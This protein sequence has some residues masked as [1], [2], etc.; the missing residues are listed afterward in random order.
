MKVLTVILYL[1]LA[2]GFSA[3]AQDALYIVD[4]QPS[5]AN[6]KPADVLTTSIL[7]SAHAVA[8]YGR[9]YKNGVTII[10]T[11]QGAIIKYQQKFGTLNKK[12]KEYIEQKHDDSNLAYVLNNTILNM[13]KKSNI[14][15]L[16]ELTPDD[17]KSISFKKDAHFTTDAT[18]VITT[19]E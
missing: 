16:Y 3:S 15:K 4:G 8:L 10:V 11:K 5:T 13:E 17:I 7:D 14:D 6:I 1:L 12:Y 2:A 19:K 18:I 9:N